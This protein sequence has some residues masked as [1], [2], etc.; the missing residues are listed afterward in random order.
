MILLNKKW[1]KEVLNK[2]RPPKADGIEF[3][4]IVYTGSW[5]MDN[6][7]KFEHWLNKAKEEL[8]VAKTLF[9]NGHWL[10]V[11]F[12]CQQSIENLLKLCILFLLMIIFLEYIILIN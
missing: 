12:M 8:N 3:L 11:A 6:Q 2:K 7:E 1:S 10:Y 5:K 4:T 9:D